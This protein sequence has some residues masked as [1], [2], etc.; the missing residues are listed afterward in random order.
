[1]LSSNLLALL[2]A[3][4]TAS[5][6][7]R[8]QA[9]ENTGVSSFPFLTFLVLTFSPNVNALLSNSIPTTVHCRDFYGVLAAL[10]CQDAAIE[11]DGGIQ[12]CHNKR[13]VRIHG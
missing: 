3:G 8:R 11:A 5:L 2:V 7:L 9:V 6:S 4:A 10:F 12:Q 13:K 1:M